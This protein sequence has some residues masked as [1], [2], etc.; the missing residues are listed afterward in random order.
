M[1]G[2]DAKK[3]CAC[4]GLQTEGGECDDTRKERAMT[5]SGDIRAV[6]ARYLKAWKPGSLGYYGIHNEGGHGQVGCSFPFS[7]LTRKELAR[8]S[9]KEE[10][11]GW[12]ARGGR[13]DSTSTHRH[14]T[15]THDNTIHDT[16]YTT[17]E[18]W[19][20]QIY[21]NHDRISDGSQVKLECSR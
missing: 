13:S 9:T 6:R 8:A 15:L 20:K 10:R 14:S 5:I 1:G 7:I 19:S 2:G 11:G 4:E 16:Q 17:A 12:P 3:R 18:K 21:K